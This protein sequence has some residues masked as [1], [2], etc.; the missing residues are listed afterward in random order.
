MTVAT[1]NNIDQ[2]IALFLTAL[3]E[4]QTGDAIGC[5]PS[6]LADAEFYADHAIAGL[7]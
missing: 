4:L 6:L 1:R 5:V 2:S 7:S 3:L